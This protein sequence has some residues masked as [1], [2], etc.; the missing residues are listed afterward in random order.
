MYGYVTPVKDKLRQQDFAL[1]RAFYC[2]TCVATK[3]Y[4]TLTRFA[5]SYDI[6]FLA[7]LVHDIASQE[8]EFTEARC[9]GNPF[10]KKLMIKP[11]PLLD[12]VCAANVILAYYKLT[13][14]V[15]DGG[16]AK[17]K[18]ARAAMKKAYLKAKATLP[19]ADESAKRR[20]E[21]LR[22]LEKRG[23]SSTDRVAHCFAT[24]LM[25]ITQAIL[26][27]KCSE[28]CASLA[29]NIGKFVY[30]ADALDDV[31]DDFKSGNYNPFL[32]RYGEF[33][34]R[35][36][37]IAAHADDL[38]FTLNATVNRAIESFNGLSFTQSYTLLANVVHDGLRAKT[39]ELLSS[40]KKL[41]RPK[42]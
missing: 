36:E 30:L 26:G 5:T 33:T 35:R 19:A 42:L 22:V 7:L 17:K 11:N 12:K 38:S 15:I 10:Q 2:G 9:V 40:E 23:E 34:N 37:F 6:T 31:D 1:Y 3:P 16:G 25:E 8:V 27:E 13:D 21:D 24:M 39:E 28:N 20:Y 32:A 4:G 41:P 18:V 29:Y 14:D